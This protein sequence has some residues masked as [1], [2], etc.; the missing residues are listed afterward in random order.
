MLA[1]ECP[2]CG[3]PASFHLTRPDVLR[4]AG[5]GY[6][7]APPPAAAA[8]LAAASSFLATLDVRTR[9]LSG[10]QQRAIE[11]ARRSATRYVIAVALLGVPFA[12]W[13]IAGVAVS[14]GARAG[15]DWGA[16]ALGLLPL[17]FYAGWTGLMARFV[18]GRARR[19]EEACA[20][21]P[22][23]AGGPAA[24]HVC[25]GT[26][27]APSGSPFVR[28]PYCAADNY[29]EPDVVRRMGEKQA[30]VLRS[31]EQE[32]A[33]RARAASETV[34]NAGCVLVPMALGAP[35]GTVVTMMI[36]AIPLSSRESPTDPSVE[37][38]AVD[39][40]AGRCI[41]RVYREGSAVVLDFGISTRPPAIV[42]REERRP[43]DAGLERFPAT[44]LVGRAVRTLEHTG[45][46]KKV[47]RTA[48]DP[49]VD[50]MSISD[51][52]RWYQGLYIPGTCLA[53]A[54]AKPAAPKPP[55]KR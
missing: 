7:G 12:I 46:V 30:V 13:A 9:Q 39:T 34:T 21:R 20:A 11:G 44:A 18:F 27:P 26:V 36:V 35:I 42:D 23:P 10:E 1:T 53:D 5:C 37:Y 38:A 55:P 28:C 29:C 33:T 4:C 54:P 2:R 22:D 45:T 32:I 40:P 43:S 19:I 3:R 41:A 50:V 15:F 51:G 49:N 17:A 16:A 48:L 6:V 24:C 31:F 47:Y 25:G 8:H 14:T 52:A